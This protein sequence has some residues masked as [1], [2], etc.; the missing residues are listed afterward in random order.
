MGMNLFQASRQWAERPA[1]ERFWSLAE[2]LGVTQGYA[3][4]AAEAKVNLGRMNVQPRENDLVLVGETGSEARFSNWAFKQMCGRLGAPS[5]YLATIKPET[6]AQ[7][8]NDGLANLEGDQR[9]SKVLFHK[10][11][12]LLARAFTSDEYARIWNWQVI[13]RLV[14]LE[15][16]GWRVPPARPA[17]DNQPGARPAKIGDVLRNNK[18]GN[19]LGIKV[20]DMIAPA[21]LYASDHDMFVFMVNED[22]RLEDGSPGGLGRGFFVSN[23]E[24]GAAAFKITKF[25]YRFVCGNHIVWDASEVEELRIRHVGMNDRRFGHRMAFTLRKYAE[26][27]ATDDQRRITTAKGFILGKDKDEV[28]DKLFGRRILPRK[29]LE[30]AYDAACL[31]ADAGN[32]SSPNTAYGMV[33]GITAL[34][35]SLAGGYMDKR[36]DMDVAAGKVLQMAF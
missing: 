2:M 11:G 33:Q 30:A 6:A 24:V 17:F 21:G 9:E 34:S 14:N 15:Q 7:C 26:S 19:G 25:L 8:L 16:D 13:E 36:M 20:G 23:S 31:D 18:G 29:T 28:I 22:N 10:N 32:N 4:E 35:Q 27:S 5:Q 3:K 12:T 1:D